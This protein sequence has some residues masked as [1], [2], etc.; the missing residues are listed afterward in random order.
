MSSVLIHNARI[1]TLAEGSVPRRGAE[2]RNLSV[3][4][5]GYIWANGDTHTYGEG[6]P[7]AEAQEPSRICDDYAEAGFPR[8]H[9]IINAHGRVVMPAFIDA[10]THACWA[11]NRLDEWDMKRSGA[12]YLDILNAGGGIMSTVSA[13]RN[14]TDEELRMSLYQR[15]RAMLAAGTCW[16]EVKSG[17]G[18]D[19][20][21]EKRMLEAIDF[22]GNCLNP[23]MHLTPTA[24]VGHAIDPEIPE[25]VERTI[26]ET[27]PAILE[28]TDD[29]C[30]IDAYCEKGAWSVEDCRRLFEKAQEAGRLFRVHADQFNSL[31]M[32]PLAVEMG[33]RSVDHLEAST[34]HDLKVL[35]ESDTFGVMLPACGFHLDDRY[36]NGRLFM[37]MGGALVIASNFNPGSAPCFS[38]PFVISLAVRHLGLTIEEA[39]TACTINAAELLNADEPD[40]KLRCNPYGHLSP[41]G[42]HHDFIMLRHT[43]ERM[44][45]YEFGGDPVQLVVSDG[46]ILKW[47][48]DGVMRTIIRH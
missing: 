24:L 4:E 30:L 26:N 17:Y 13:T 16:A 10:H 21:S 38:M 7:P 36:A 45:A 39:I 5:R 18:L 43:D 37:D 41:I 34:E 3:I 44:L 33:A 8:T 28:A 25:F 27:L 12:S 19:G 48:G 47:T 14:A 40:V 42:V 2:A 1:L 6:D 32:T 22:V 31:G 29:H 15:A 11:G 35:A 46:R 23:F 20:A 9:T